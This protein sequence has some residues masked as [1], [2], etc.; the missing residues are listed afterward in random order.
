MRGVLGGG[1]EWGVL[2]EDVSGSGVEVAGFEE[3]RGALIIS[4]LHAG[5]GVKRIGPARSGK[6]DFGR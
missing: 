6:E 1:V 5:R 2:V 3:E 4:E